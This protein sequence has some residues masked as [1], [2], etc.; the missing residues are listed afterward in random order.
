M[1]SDSVVG[2]GGEMGFST[3]KLLCMKFEVSQVEMEL[4]FELATETAIG[5][6]VVCQFF[7]DNSF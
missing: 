2:L 5:A 6:L 3:E 4:L 1:G 7:R